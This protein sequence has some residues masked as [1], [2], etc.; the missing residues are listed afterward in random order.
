MALFASIIL[1]VP[2]PI[3]NGLQLFAR[4]YLVVAIGVLVIRS[5]PVLVDLL[6]S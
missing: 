3:A 5:T 6:N 1:P 2:R 4:I